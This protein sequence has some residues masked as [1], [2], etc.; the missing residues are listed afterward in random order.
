MINILTRAPNLKFPLDCLIPW[1]KKT[2][3]TLK[4]NVWIMHWQEFITKLIFFINRVKPFRATLR[5]I[6]DSYHVSTMFHIF[7]TSTLVLK[8]MFLSSFVI[9]IEKQAFRAYYNALI[10]RYTFAI[11]AM[12]TRLFQGTLN[13]FCI[14]LAWKNII[15]IECMN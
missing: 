5:H 2:S 10:I 11:L 1:L 13:Y 7:L 4:L 14:S 6:L 9:G 12:R 15:N 8:N 3:A